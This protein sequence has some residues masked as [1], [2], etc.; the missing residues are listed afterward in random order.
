MTNFTNATQGIP[1]GIPAAIRRLQMDH[2]PGANDSVNL[3]VNLGDEVINRTTAAWWK[4]ISLANYQATW[5]RFAFSPGFVAT[6]TGNSGGAVAPD[7]TNQNINTLGDVTTITVAGNPSTNTLTWSVGPTVA[8]SYPTNSGT[9]IPALSV[10]NVLGAGGTTTSGSGNT[11]TITSTGVGQ[12]I[13]QAVS[14]VATV[15]K[16]YFVTA[17]ATI[18]TPATASQGDHLH[19]VADTTG[20]VIVQANTGQTL[21][22]NNVASSV[23]GSATNSARGDSLDF[24]YRAA[25]STWICLSTEG[26]WSLA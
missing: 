11:I 3:G 2:N 10:L 14:V 17:A 21:R 16:G 26:L 13:D 19:V 5:V 24:V 12:W 7:A 23:A 9:A 6:L 20:T 8:T 22:V 25:T 4:L 18:T 1:S 15:N